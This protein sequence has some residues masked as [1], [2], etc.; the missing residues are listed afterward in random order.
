MYHTLGGLNNQHLFLTVLE[1]G[2]PR[3]GFQHGWVSTVVRSLI[4]VPDGPLLHTSSCGRKSERTHWGLSYKDTNTTHE[5]F[6]LMT[7]SLPKAPFANTTTFEGQNFKMGVLVGYKDSF[8]HIITVSITWNNVS[9]CD[10][11]CRKSFLNI[12]SFPTDTEDDEDNL[13]SFL[14]TKFQYSHR[15][16]K[17]MCCQACDS[18][19]IM[20]ESFNGTAEIFNEKVT[21]TLHIFKRVYLT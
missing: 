4:Q 8:H 11:I 6:T 1:S 14:K 17:N 19:V 13:N 16:L 20:C 10:T 9:H 21:R 5:S 18:T 3:S 7:H 15:Y 12:S 2:D